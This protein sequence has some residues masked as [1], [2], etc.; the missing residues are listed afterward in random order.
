MTKMKKTRTYKDYKDFNEYLNENYANIPEEFLWWLH[1][2]VENGDE[3]EAIRLAKRLFLAKSFKEEGYE[4]HPI[5]PSLRK[6]GNIIPLV[7]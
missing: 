5:S 7:E 6:N 3:E 4:L 2:A 1:T